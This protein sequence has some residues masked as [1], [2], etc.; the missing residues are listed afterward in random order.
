MDKYD[1]IYSYSELLLDHKKEQSADTGYHMVEPWKCYA[2][3]KKPDTQGHILCD[4]TYIKCP[5]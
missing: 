3:W 4:S 1:V 2:N 5:E